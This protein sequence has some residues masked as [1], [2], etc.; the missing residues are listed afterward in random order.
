M[1]QRTTKDLVDGLLEKAQGEGVLRAGLVVGFEDRTEMVWSADSAPVRKLND[2][3]RKGGIPLGLARFLDGGLEVD[4]LPEFEGVAW[5]EQYLA[6]V[7][8]TIM[9]G[10]AEHLGAEYQQ[11]QAP[12]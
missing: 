5:A 1:E 12:E 8:G 6:S 3:M 7:A 9:R 11:A 4:P 10:L 2:L